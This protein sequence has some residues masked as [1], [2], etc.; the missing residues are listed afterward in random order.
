VNDT[1]TNWFTQEAPELL[2]YGG[3]QELSDY[4]RDQESMQVWSGKFLSEVNTL[5][6]VEDRAA[7]SGST[8]G[9]TPGGSTTGRFRL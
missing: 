5:Q 6:A 7:W 3:L 9:V 4:A 1:D 8:I 2:L